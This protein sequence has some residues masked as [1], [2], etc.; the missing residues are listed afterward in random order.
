MLTLLCRYRQVLASGTWQLLEPQ[1][2][3]LW[4][5]RAAAGGRE[6]PF[7]RL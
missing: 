7:D 4:A 6:M 3:P 2:R 1:R 5:P